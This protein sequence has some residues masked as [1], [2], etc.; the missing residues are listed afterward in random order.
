MSARTFFLATLG[1]KVNQYESHALREAWLAQG[2]LEAA[3]PEEADVI[4]VNSCAVTAKAVADVRAVLRRLRRA[5]PQATIIMTGCAANLPEREFAG[6]EGIRIVPQNAK[7]DLLAG[8]PET[9]AANSFLEG[10]KHPGAYPNFALSGYDRSRAVLK[11][12]DGCS[13]GC[14]YCIVPLTRGRARSRRGADALDEAER[15]LRAGFREI[16]ISGINLRQFRWTA[17]PG[18]LQ[19]DFW[20]WLAWMDRSLAPQW[21]GKARFRISS[22]EPGQLGDKALDVLAGCSLVAPHLH[23][24]LQSGSNSVLR[25][26]GRSHY[27]PAELPGFLEKLRPLWPLFGLGADILTAF[28]GETDEEYD[29]GL[30]LFQALPLTYAHVFPYS[31]RPGTPAAAMPGQIPT[32]TAKERAAHIRALVSAKRARFLRSLAE[33][34]PLMQV[35]FEE[36]R[37]NSQ[38]ASDERSEKE[39]QDGMPEKA[40]SSIRGVNEFYVECRLEDARNQD[41]R[42]SGMTAVRPLR[43]DGRSLWVCVAPDEKDARR[44]EA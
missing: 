33:Q 27:N 39:K 14:A 43:T 7:E 13:H 25:R 36:A 29:E 10:R 9:D 22:L 38:R 6:L 20:D 37:G 23:L 31:R 8:L 44:E 40:A 28:P 41:R 30:E 19:E 17:K 3:L 34:A 18:S 24:S 32:G 42:A 15:L 2:M 11:I 16:V 5:A 21:A 12:Q 26:M 35:V 1:C 4:V